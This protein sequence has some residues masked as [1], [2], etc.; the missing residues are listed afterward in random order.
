[1]FRAA[2]KIG[3]T[4]LVG[5]IGGAMARHNSVTN[6]KSPLKNFIQTNILKTTDDN[7]QTDNI[8]TAIGGVAGLALGHLMGN[9]V[10]GNGN[11]P[12]PPQKQPTSGGFVG[13]VI[14]NSLMLGGAVL[15]GA[16]LF[17]VLNP[18]STTAE[19]ATTV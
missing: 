2:A 8:A 19:P 9:V 4:M 6:P 16:F 7:K 15:G 1:M 10:L 5:T 14:K 17:G 12:A 11:P 13:S 18:K 3:T